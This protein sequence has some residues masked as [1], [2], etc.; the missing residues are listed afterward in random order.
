MSGVDVSPSAINLRF[1]DS[2]AD[3]IFVAI[4]ASGTTESTEEI[5]KRA[6]KM[7]EELVEIR[8]GYK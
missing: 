1:I 5:Y 7:A 8:N 3:K 2:M 6:R 4:V